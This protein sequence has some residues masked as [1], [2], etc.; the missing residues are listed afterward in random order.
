VRPQGPVTS[1][2]EAIRQAEPGDTI[3]IE[4]GVYMGNLRLEK[5][6]ALEGVGSPRILG[7]GSGSVITVLADGCVIRGLVIERSGRALVEEDSG[8]LVKSNRN[9]IEEN[10]IRDVLYGI[11]LYAAHDNLIRGNR[12]R[13]RTELE[14]GER[15]NGIHVWN[16]SGNRILA[17]TISHM[18]D[19]LYLQNASRS[20]IRENRAFQLRYGLHYMFSDENVIE[21][22]QFFDNVA[23]AAIMYSRRIRLQRNIFF[24]NRGFSSYGLLFQDCDDCVI[25]ENLIADNAVGIFM[26]ALRRSLFR[27]NLI[28]TNDVAVYLFSSASENVFTENSFVRNVSLLRVIGRG[29]TTRWSWQGVGNYWDDYRGFDAEGDGIGD[30][31]FRLQDLFERLEGNH[32]RLRVYLSSAAAEALAF[33]ERAFP[34]IPEPQEWDPAPL[35]KP[36]ALWPSEVVGI[37]RAPAPRWGLVAPMAMIGISVSVFL[38]ARRR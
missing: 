9:R 27:R 35:Q 1:V 12:I 14:F 3:R 5:P 16:S 23:G 7:E 37:E 28:V 10:E 19:G 26:E 24:R 20:L 34:I 6:L 21:G 18:R 4:A 29:T 31:P 15:G 25:Q 33:A 17:N 36:R 30:V 8:I 2:R 13:G 11:Y 22:N 32:P 38:W